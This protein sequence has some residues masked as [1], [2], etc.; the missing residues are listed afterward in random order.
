MKRTRIAKLGES[1]GLE[2]RADAFNIFNRTNFSLPSG[3]I[4]AGTTGANANAGR[5]SNITGTARQLQ[6]SARFVF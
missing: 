5:I 6:F 1:A 3:A 2:I 4:F